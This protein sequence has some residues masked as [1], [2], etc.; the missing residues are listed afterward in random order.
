MKLS[1]D[2]EASMRS[3]RY[4]PHVKERTSDGEM[5]RPSTVAG[6]ILFCSNIPMSR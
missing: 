3:A 2:L 4:V 6:G 1:E 5:G